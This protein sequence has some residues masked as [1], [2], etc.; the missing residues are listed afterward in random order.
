MAAS[1]NFRT[2][3]NGFNREDVVHYI[4]YI[5]SK[6]TALVNQLRSDLASAQQEAATLRTTPP[7]NSEL[8]EQVVQLNARIAQLEDELL[9]AQIAKSDA[10]AGLEAM[11]KQRDEALAAQSAVKNNSEAELE[12]YRRAE[13]MEREAKERADAM[14][15]QA[16]GIIADASVK[17][18]EAAQHINGIADQVAEQLSVLQN[19]ILDSKS[20]LKDACVSMSNIRP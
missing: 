4:E 17:V 20:A 5:N 14:Y 2:A 15:A 10:E 19:A 11:T 16:N 6:H 12:T 8:D 7:Q 3:F 9:V 18:D 1:Y 13:R